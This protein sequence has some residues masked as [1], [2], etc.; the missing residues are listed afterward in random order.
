M[1]KHKSVDGYKTKRA[2]KKLP[3][4]RPLAPDDFDDKYT[5]DDFY[6]RSKIDIE[7]YSGDCMKIINL[8]VE[9]MMVIDKFQKNEIL[10]LIESNIDRHFPEEDA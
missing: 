5:S 1:A 6:T 7:Y 3:K 2:Y 8:M 9:Q 10:A 4:Q